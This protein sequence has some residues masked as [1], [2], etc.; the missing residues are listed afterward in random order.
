M[1]PESPETFLVD[2]PNLPHSGTTVD[3]EKVAPMAIDMFVRMKES[4]KKSGKGV[5]TRLGYFGKFGS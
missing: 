3:P 1:F 4:V 2:I 5:L